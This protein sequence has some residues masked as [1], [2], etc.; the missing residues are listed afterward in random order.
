MPIPA[1]PARLMT[2]APRLIVFSPNWLGDAV[3][4]LPAIDDLRRHLGARIVVVARRSVARLF[5]LVPW[6]DEVVELEW[7]GGIADVGA[8][9]R[10]IRRV[11]SLGAETARYIGVSWSR[12]RFPGSSRTSSD[13]RNVRVFASGASTPP[14]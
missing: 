5:T 6:V 9:R 13:A 14:K 2:D 8:M 1:T 7:R 3:M 10:D 11:K 4:A 12:I